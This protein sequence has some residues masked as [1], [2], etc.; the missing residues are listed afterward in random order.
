[1]ELFLEIVKFLVIICFC[2]RCHQRCLAGS[3][4]CLWIFDF[5]IFARC[6]TNFTDFRN[7]IVLV[8][9][10]WDD[11]DSN[12]LTVVSTVIHVVTIWDFLANTPW[13]TFVLFYYINVS[14]SIITRT[15]CFNYA[16]FNLKGI[17][18]FRQVFMKRSLNQNVF[19]NNCF[20]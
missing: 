15:C 14:F 9:L 20:Q 2:K 7:F 8:A 17:I 4:I 13:N 6:E 16:K 18:I 5:K 3:W 1:M 10:V 19:S 11:E 12:S